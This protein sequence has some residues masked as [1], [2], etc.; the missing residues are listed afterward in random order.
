LSEKFLSLVVRHEPEI[1]WDP[2]DPLATLLI[3]PFPVTGSALVA[4]LSVRP[5]AVLELDGRI[6]RLRE[7]LKAGDPD[8]AADEIMAVIERAEA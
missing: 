4:R 1:A 6:A 7:R 2:V 3:S 8:M 5:A